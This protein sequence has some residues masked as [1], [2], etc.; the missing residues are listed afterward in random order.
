MRDANLGVV[1]LQ[2]CI[3]YVLIHH[4]PLAAVHVV[5]VVVHAATQTNVGHLEGSRFQYLIG[6][7]AHSHQMN[8]RPVPVVI[9]PGAI[10][11][12]MRLDLGKDVPSNRHRPA[13]KGG[14]DPIGFRDGIRVTE[15]RVKGHTEKVVAQVFSVNVFESFLDGLIDCWRDNVVFLHKQK[16]VYRLEFLHSE[17]GVHQP[18]KVVL[19]AG[20]LAFSFVP[21]GIPIVALVQL[22]IVSRKGVGMLRARI[23]MEELY[24]MEF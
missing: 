20:D 17:D 22:W 1:G 19:A 24:D 16:A 6:K 9:V 7:V 18:G 3:R 10:V 12:G 5:P 21:V 2:P 4:R 15:T 11:L 14:L 8:D 13:H 23:G